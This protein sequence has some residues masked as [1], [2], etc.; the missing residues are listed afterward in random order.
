MMRVRITLGETAV[1]ASLND[2]ETARL[3][4][5]ALPIESKAQVWGDE[6]YEWRLGVV[7][8]MLSWSVRVSASRFGLWSL[9]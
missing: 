9:G 3:L 7:S 2:S 6:V 1:T 4:A 5:A 8:Q